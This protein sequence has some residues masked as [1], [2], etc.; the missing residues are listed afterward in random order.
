MGNQNLP[1]LTQDN[2]F[3]RIECMMSSS[4]LAFSVGKRGAYLGHK[5]VFFHFAGGTYRSH[6]FSSTL[7]CDLKSLY[8]ATRRKFSQGCSKVNEG[9]K[10]IGKEPH[11]E[12]TFMQKFLGPK[13]MPKRGTFQWYREMSL[14][15]TVFAITGTSTMFLVSYSRYL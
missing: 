4:R 9:G 8:M 2:Y 13:E 5:D 12:K 14:L 11:S 6:K 7:R 10:G 1:K 15:C 3:L